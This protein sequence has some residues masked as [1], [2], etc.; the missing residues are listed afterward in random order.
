MKLKNKIIPG[1]LLLASFSLSSCDDFLTQVN[2]NEITSSSYYTSIADCES[3]LAAVYNQFKDMDCYRIVEEIQRSDIGT[4][5]TWAFAARTNFSNPFYMQTFG[6]AE[7]AVNAKWE[8]LYKGVFR[9]NQLIEGLDKFYPSITDDATR[10]EWNVIMAEARFFRGLF[11]YWLSI[12]YN[13]GNVPIVKAVPS[14]EASL[15]MPL[16]EGGAAEVQ[17]FYR[18]EFLAALEYGL[19]E[20]WP[21]AKAGR[22]TSGTVKT[23]LG[24]SYLYEGDFATAQ[25]YFKEVIDSGIYS[26]AKV[27]ENTATTGEFNSESI[28]E[29]NYTLDYNTEFTS[30]DQRLSNTWHTNF[31]RTPGS[32][33]SVFPAGWYT[34]LCQ[35]E[36]P[37]DPTNEMNW[38]E[39]TL[40]EDGN[41]IYLF[42]GKD[43]SF[44]T[45]NED[46][47]YTKLSYVFQKYND[48]D[49]EF[50]GSDYSRDIKRLSRF[51][52]A[53][54][55][56]DEEKTDYASHGSYFNHTVV[57]EVN[58]KYYKL[59]QQ[60]PRGSYRLAQPTD[61]DVPYYQTTCAFAAAW[62]NGHLGYFREMTNYDIWTKELD[63]PTTGQ[64]AVN[65]RLM[66]LSDVY[67]MYAECLVKTGGSTQTALDYINKLRFRG[68]ATLLG[69][70]G[71]FETLASYDG[72][73]YSADD[74]MNQL[75]F[76][77]RPLEVGF[78][79]ATRVCD[80]RRWGITKQRFAELS[81][82]DMFMGPC[83]YNYPHKTG[84]GLATTAVWR[85]G[86]KAYNAE[87]AAYWNSWYP[88]TQT[89]IYHDYTLAA[90]NYTDE[91]NAY[92]PIP[93]KEILA[94]P[95][96]N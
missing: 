93:N 28:L 60:T 96:L 89:T 46:G 30:Q 85:W 37:V 48:E 20:T 70:G 73:A 62:T 9:A 13:G 32:Y 84:P 52:D 74:I 91:K 90:L 33:F 82:A 65:L 50:F 4:E 26:L 10:K 15:Y 23:Y 63:S 76:V 34:L 11:H 83:Y 19:P 86:A 18:A 56:L 14:D 69:E 68:G 29:V 57:K 45:T 38:R 54:G 59:V 80:L 42:N 66:T 72:E 64:S 3:S 8:A 71:E 41:V 61:E 49:A 1:L 12:S 95:N 21:A 77:E 40:D 51:Y 78:G 24:Q 47:S 5:G 39:V 81:S 75:M 94:N 7:A 27:N 22:I 79:Q 16:P 35:D 36:D 17:D 31:S 87:T 43:Y 88:N 25:E 2:P 53:S 58:G 67:L 92:L 44:T 6:N 55:V